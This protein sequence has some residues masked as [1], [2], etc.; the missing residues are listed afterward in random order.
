MGGE[1]FSFNV[2][3]RQD[4]IVIEQSALEES[5]GPATKHRPAMPVTYRMNHHKK[6]VTLNESHLG[7]LSLWREQKVN[8]SLLCSDALHDAFKSK[9]LRFFRSYKTRAA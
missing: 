9:G 6:D 2:Y 1:W 7:A 4:S 8:E 5:G 3:A